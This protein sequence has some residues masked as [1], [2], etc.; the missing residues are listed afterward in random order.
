M[1][2]VVK[3]WGGETNWAQMHTQMCRGQD[4]GSLEMLTVHGEHTQ[5]TPSTHTEALE[6]QTPRGVRSCIWNSHREL[7]GAKG[8]VSWG[9]SLRQ[10]LCGIIY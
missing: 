8:W 7:K 5:I 6:Q 1:G 2:V 10:R 9:Q 4:T 3:P